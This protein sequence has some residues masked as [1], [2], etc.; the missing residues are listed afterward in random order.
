MFCLRWIERMEG[1]SSSGLCHHTIA[2]EVIGE[3]RSI[4]SL[5][6]LLN[7]STYV[8]EIRIWSTRGVEIDPENWPGQS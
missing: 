8:T 3:K 6:S 2:G 4:E 7:D 5:Y 1:I